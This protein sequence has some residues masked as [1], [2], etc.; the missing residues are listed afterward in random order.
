M[1]ESEKGCVEK[2]VNSPNGFI[3]FMLRPRLAKRH[4]SA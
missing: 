3:T 4:I 2:N 1:Y